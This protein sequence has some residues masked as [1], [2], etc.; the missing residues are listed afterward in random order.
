MDI[1]NSAKNLQADYDLWEYLLVASPTKEISDKVVGEKKSFYENYGHKRLLVFT[2]GF[3][4]LLQ[5]FQICCY[6]EPVFSLTIS[7]SDFSL[8]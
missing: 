3:P 7:L 8:E 1:L 5:T 2:F 4:G 6:A